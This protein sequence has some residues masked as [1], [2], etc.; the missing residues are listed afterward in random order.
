MRSVLGPKRFN[1]LMD[2]MNDLCEGLAPK[3]NLY[4][5]MNGPLEANLLMS[6][7]LAHMVSNYDEIYRLMAPEVVEGCTVIELGCYS[8]T[9]SRWLARKHPEI[10]VVGID[11]VSWLPECNKPDD[12]EN[13][14]LV[15]CDYEDAESTA[16]KGD[17]LF[18]SF[19]IDFSWLEMDLDSWMVFDF[20]GELIGER[21]E[22]ADQALR[23]LQVDKFCDEPE[24]S[25]R[26][27]SRFTA[28]ESAGNV[29]ATEDAARY[30]RCWSQIA[31]PN[32]SLVVALRVAHIF[33][34]CSILQGSASA[35][36]AVDFEKSCAISTEEETFRVLYFRQ[37]ES[38]T[39]GV[40]GEDV[41]RVVDISSK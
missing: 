9:Y 37:S 21:E 19:P 32:S 17:V 27:N 1:Q 15:C 40:T 5:L 30:F 10:N 4:E 13:M 39:L 7:Q 23:C 33:H 14:G 22:L 8:G 11:R 3:Q 38:G 26:T 28:W 36:W 41:Y 12:P 16:S 29:K 25:Q 6:F 20:A 31:N 35:S 2:T 34:L 18:G 24:R